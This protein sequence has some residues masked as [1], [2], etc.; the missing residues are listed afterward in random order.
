[1]GNL[2]PNIQRSLSYSVG[3]EAD[4]SRFCGI[5]I[6]WFHSQIS[7]IFGHGGQEANG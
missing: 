2:C 1:M 4:Y 6:F 5:H 3:L 7:I